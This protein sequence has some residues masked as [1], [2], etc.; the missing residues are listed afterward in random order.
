MIIVLT[1]VALLLLWG[2]R[3]RSA[4]ASS[5]INLDD[6]LLGDDGKVS[7]AKFVLLGSFGLN[8]WLIIWLTLHDK[9]DHEYLYAFSGVYAIPSVAKIL[10]GNVSEP[11]KGV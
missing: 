1:I 10:K 7:T 4:D 6:F 5:Q 3:R 2:L 9:M 11:P 8:C